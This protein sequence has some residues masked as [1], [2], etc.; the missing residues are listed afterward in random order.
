MTPSQKRAMAAAL[1]TAIAMPA[2]GLRQVM[3][4]DP[5]GIPTVCFGHTGADVQRGKTYSLEECKALLTGDM[6]K[7]LNA[8]DR[9]QPGLPPQ[10]LAAFGDA[11]YNMGP[12]IACNRGA[13]TA[14]RLLAARDLAGACRQL[15]KWNKARVAGVLV[16]LPGLT[17]RRYAEMNLCLE[18]VG[19]YQAKVS[20]LTAEDLLRPLDRTPENLERL[21]CALNGGGSGCQPRESAPRALS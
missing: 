6:A 13:S 9:C 21:R 18:G 11:A 10:V 17:K 8:V 14:A 5:P 16:E 1:A 4:R 20:E 12:T 19:Q 2:E 7:A 3:Y 15:P